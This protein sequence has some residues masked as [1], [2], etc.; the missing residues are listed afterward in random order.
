[1]EVITILQLL[2]ALIILIKISYQDHKKAKVSSTDLLILAGFM[3]NFWT[4]ILF[5]IFNASQKI[6]KT[7]F[8]D[9]FVIGISQLILGDYF[10]DLILIVLIIFISLFLLGK[11]GI[12]AI[13][14][15]TLSLIIAMLLKLFSMHII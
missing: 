2:G 1:M 8:G 13:P 6:I 4:G 15:I 12:K 5:V 9:I 11:R 10:T 14:W 3:I 7:G